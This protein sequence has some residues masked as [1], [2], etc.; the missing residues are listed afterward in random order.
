VSVKV[1][2]TD[3]HSARAH[4]GDVPAG[5]ERVRRRLELIAEMARAYYEED[6]TQAQ[7]A[8][9]YGLSRSQVSRYLQAARDEGIVQIRVV[10]PDARD[11]EVESDLRRAWPH[12]REVVVTRVFDREPMFVRRAVGRAAARVFDRLIDP[13]QTL[14][15]GA[16]RTMAVA[17]GMLTS[18]AT[19]GLIVVPATG[20]AGHA[21][22]ESDYSAVVRTVAEALGAVAYHINAP[23]ILG[24]NASSGQL[25]RSNP[26]IAQALVVARRADLYL[27]GMGSLGGDE[28]FVRTGLISAQELAA[29]RD[30]G[31]VG[32]LCGNFFDAAGCDQP[33]PFRDRVMGITLDDL[34]RASL[35]IAVAGGAE[36]V[37]AI[38]GALR[39]RLING[40]VTDE[41]TARGVLA[42]VGDGTAGAVTTGAPQGGA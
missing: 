26:Q 14:C 37:M 25:E 11:A 22:F 29:V 8:A 15:V 3:V 5:E 2:R 39:G 21:A 30:A 34:S 10:S 7:V 13:G 41:H 23:A 27:L 40:L 35:A 31:A 32:D 1:A 6:M 33:G 38:A 12:L 24:S 4:A 20:D 19:S 9:A 42:V 36:K 28:I 17:A 18:R 16:G